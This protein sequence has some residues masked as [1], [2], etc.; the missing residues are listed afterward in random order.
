[1]TH[2]SEPRKAPPPA[3]SPGGS[4]QPVIFNPGGEIPIDGG[5]PVSARLD[6]PATSTDEASSPVLPTNQYRLQGGPVS[7]VYDPTNADPSETAGPI[8]LRYQDGELSLD[9]HPGQVRYDVVANVGTFITAT[10]LAGQADFTTASL[11]LPDVSLRPG[12]STSVEALLITRSHHLD[13]S[14]PGGPHGG[15][16]SVAELSGD[17]FR[18]PLT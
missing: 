14:A 1:M 10:L 8:I 3:D 5:M 2:A 15:S 12:E 16:Y 17:A 6:S 11:L 7:I 18:P 9:F 13:V 4:E